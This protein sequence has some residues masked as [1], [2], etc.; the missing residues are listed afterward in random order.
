[1]KVWHVFIYFAS[2]DLIS[3]HQTSD[4]IN[5]TIEIVIRQEDI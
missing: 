1:M 3:Y 2:Q 5:A 4:G